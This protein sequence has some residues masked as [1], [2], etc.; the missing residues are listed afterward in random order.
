MQMNLHEMFKNLNEVFTN[1]RKQ[2]TKSRK[3]FCKLL[4]ITP[5]LIPMMMQFAFKPP[6]EVD[7]LKAHSMR[8][9]L[10]RIQCEHKQ[11][12]LIHFQCALLS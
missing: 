3:V 1:L 12:E 2:F 10:M 5:A 7:W 8:T 4:Y 11:C 6:I 9:A